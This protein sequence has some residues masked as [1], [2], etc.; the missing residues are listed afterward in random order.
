MFRF[1]ELDTL[2]KP[3][4]GPH[5]TPSGLVD[6]VPSTVAVNHTESNGFEI[7]DVAKPSQGA[8]DIADWAGE[9][10]PSMRK[11]RQGMDSLLKTSRLLCSVLRLQQLKE[12]VRC[13]RQCWGSEFERIRR[14]F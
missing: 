11:L 2:K 8:E 14:F 3:T 7:P 4:T 6:Q 12:A 9:V 13:Y 10:R 5:N 1:R